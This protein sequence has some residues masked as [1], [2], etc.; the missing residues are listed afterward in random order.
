MWGGGSIEP[1][2]E[3]NKGVGIRIIVY[4]IANLYMLV[5][6]VKYY[7]LF[8]TFLATYILVYS[9]LKDE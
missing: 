2:A 6:V 8:T 1:Q 3:M 4:N 9:I 5:K 7:D